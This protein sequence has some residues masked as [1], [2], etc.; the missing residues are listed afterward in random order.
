MQVFFAQCYVIS[1]F[2]YVIESVKSCLFSCDLTKQ[3]SNSNHLCSS[4]KQP[5]FAGSY[6]L[7]NRL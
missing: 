1:I 4:I 5:I 6:L 3:V 7:K 2:G